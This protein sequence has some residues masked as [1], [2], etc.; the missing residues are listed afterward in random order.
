MSPEDLVR[1]AHKK[2][3]KA[4]D[5]WAEWRK[6][7][8]E[9]YDFVSG[10]QWSDDDRAILQE[11]LRPCI[12]FNRTE[13]IIDAISGAEIS[14]RQEVRYLPREQGDVEVNEVLTA[15]A[16][17]VRDNCDAEDEESDSFLDAVICGVGATETFMDYESDPDGSIEIARVDPLE[18]YPDPDAKKRNF[19]D[20]KCVFRIREW[21]IEEAVERWPDKEDEIRAAMGYKSQDQSD[22]EIES[23]DPPF[24]DDPE[25][26][27]NKKNTVDIIQYQYTTKVPYYRAVNPFSGQI[28]SVN[29]ENFPMLRKQAEMR[30][31]RI[32]AT[33]MM[34]KEYRQAFIVGKT[35]LEDEDGPCK[36]GFSL[37]FVTAKRDRNKNTWYGVVRA[38]MDPQRWANKFFSQILHTINT[39]AK[40]GVIA[41]TGAVDDTRKFEKE[42]ANPSG[43]TW[44]T[45]GA[46][47]QGKIT[48]KPESPYPNGLDRL[49]DFS[50]NSM[51]DVVGVSPELMGMT[52]RDQAGVLEYQ[53]RQAGM[54][55]LARL[56]DGLRRYRKEQGRVLLHFIQEYISDGRLVRVL[57][58]GQEQ[59]VPLMRQPD[60]VKYDVIVDESPSSPNMK[61]RVW[62]ILTQMLPTLLQAGIPVPPE[63]M[64]YTP[65]PSSLT[66]KWM[67]MMNKQPS[68]Q[69]QAAAQ[70]RMQREQAETTKT[71]ADA[72]K[73]QADAQ[74]AS[75]AAQR[76]S[77]ML[78][79][80]M[81]QALARAVGEALNNALKQKELLTPPDKV[82]L[83]EGD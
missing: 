64:E 13:P 19:D 59:Y 63:V 14:N 46:V 26:S 28:E 25:V 29:A 48:N 3:A 8:R 36:Y 49:M 9:C 82:T 38:M 5:H 76:A 55:V 71:M 11:Q 41:E 21:D 16:D 7:A 39:N 65:L 51:R 33:K 83:S 81:E 79:P 18:C 35:L 70:L 37:K 54:V 45:P 17:W 69:E 40:G 42:W 57:S 6:E 31:V 58:Q 30:G 74:E 50:I 43:V 61:D 53:R 24:Y 67:G 66:K 10:H 32:R 27:E 15:A 4:K 60:T 22:G 12:T 23:G 62:S 56:F 77:A 72:Q 20:G 52:G 2:L 78:S 75:V 73:A 68:P 47:A 44:V 34:R 1:Q 80:E